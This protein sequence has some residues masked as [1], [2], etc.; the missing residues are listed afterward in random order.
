VSG[1]EWK[2]TEVGH[3]WSPWLDADDHTK[4]IEPCCVCDVD[5]WEVMPVEF[6]PPL[7]E[8]R[9]GMAVLH[10]NI[11]M[12]NTAVPE[13]PL[14]CAARN[15]FWQIPASELKKLAGH[16]RI[17]A[18]SKFTLFQIVEMLLRHVFDDWGTDALY[19]VVRLRLKILA[20]VQ[21]LFA[22]LTNHEVAF[23][24]LILLR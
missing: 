14:R 2:D 18:P 19:D 22:S 3:N 7:D 17:D 23:A 20:Q 16:F 1:E 12:L 6:R 8:R 9:S 5:D 21:D 24:C 15:C 13:H 11:V 4:L 10:S